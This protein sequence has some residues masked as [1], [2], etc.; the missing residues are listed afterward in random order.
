M[1]R[2][3][4]QLSQGVACIPSLSLLVCLSMAWE[5]EAEEE[6]EEAAKPKEP[7]MIPGLGQCV[8]ILLFPEGSE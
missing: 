5:V 8:I 4:C 3:Y 7:G 6:A 1:L 2:C